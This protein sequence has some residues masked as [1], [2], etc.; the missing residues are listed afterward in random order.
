MYAA[1]ERS[2]HEELG[3][4]P[5]PEARALAVRLGAAAPARPRL[6]APLTALVGREVEGGEILALLDRPDCR[7]LSLVGP[8]GVGKTRL[9][10]AVA[11]RLAESRPVYWVEIKGRKLISSLAEGLGLSLLGRTDAREAVLHQLQEAPSLVVLDEA[12]H[13]EE[14]GELEALLREAPG[15][16]LL[17]TTRRRFRLHSEWVYEVHGLHQAEE[18]RSVAQSPA[19]ELFLSAAERVRPGW[20]PIPQDWA[21][22]GRICHLLSGLPLGLE[23]AAGW[24]RLMSPPEI[25]GHLSGSLELLEGGT[26]GP[27]EHHASLRAVLDSTLERLTPSERQTLLGLCTFRGSFD[28]GAAKAVAGATPALLAA[29]GDHALVQVSQGGYTILEVIRQHLAGDIPVEAR[30]RHGAYYRGLV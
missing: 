25:E 17:L 5:S 11:Q 12:E 16:K 2:L 1:L 30:E 19:A 3:V 14:A 18:G 27:D 15:L 28:L 9:A 4:E 20:R 6:P 22:I 10:L 26:P 29:L 23:L 7:F 24:V 8:G 13:L 21:A